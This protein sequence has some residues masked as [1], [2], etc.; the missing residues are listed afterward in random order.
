MTNMVVVH[1]KDIDRG[2]VRFLKKV[3]GMQVGTEGGP[4]GVEGDGLDVRYVAAAHGCLRSAE[5][6]E[7]RTSVGGWHMFQEPGDCVE[8]LEQKSSGK[9]L[10]E[11]LKRQ[12]ALSAMLLS[13]L[14]W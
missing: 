5:I 1:L 4:L 11:K 8:Y 14:G 7:E 2:E 6:I 9:G 12:E 13:S 3:V 10:V